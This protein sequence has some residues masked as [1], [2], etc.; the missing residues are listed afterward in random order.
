VSDDKQFDKKVCFSDAEIISAFSNGMGPDDHIPTHQ[1]HAPLLTNE[2]IIWVVRR[3]VAGSRFTLSARGDNQ[4][5]LRDALAYINHVGSSHVMRGQP[6]PQEWLVKKLEA[7]IS[8]Y[9]GCSS[10][11]AK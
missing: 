6:H 9:V 10:K 2:Q 3:F 11:E 8:Q 1:P 7:A 4:E 5:V